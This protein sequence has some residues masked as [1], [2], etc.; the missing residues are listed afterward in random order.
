MIFYSLISRL[1]VQLNGIPLHITNCSS[2]E[3]DLPTYTQQYRHLFFCP[4]NS[5]FMLLINLETVVYKSGTGIIQLVQSEGCRLDELKFNS[6]KGQEIFFFSGIFRLDLWPAQAPIQCVLGGLFNRDSVQGVK[7][8]DHSAPCSA[9]VKNEWYYT[10]TSAIC[11]H[12][13]IFFR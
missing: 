10:S 13:N 4:Y 1:Y 5:S 6:Q 12:M 11:L 7:L 3:P 9:K 8:T 2:C